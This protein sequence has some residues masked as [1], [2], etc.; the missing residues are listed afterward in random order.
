MRFD[1]GCEF[2]D[3]PDGGVYLD[4]DNLPDCPRVWEYL[5]EGRTKGIFQLEKYA[6]R[7]VCKNVMPQNK[8]QISAAITIIRPGCSKV[9]DENNITT[10]QHYEARKNGMEDVTYFH[11]EAEEILHDAYGLMIYQEHSIRLAQKFAGFDLKQADILRKA[12][13]KKDSKL[14]ASLEGEFIEGINK[15]GLLTEEEGRILFAAIRKSERYSFCKC[16]SGKETIRRL[17]KN[18]KHGVK[19]SIEEMFNIRND[20][21]YAK[22]TGHS[23]LRRKW[24]RLGNYGF[25]LSIVEGR[26]K[27]NLIKDI[28]YQGIRDVFQIELDNKATIV[29]TNN[30]KF[31][32]Q[33]GDKVLS[34]L[35]IGDSLL[36]CGKYENT[37][38]NY[39]FSN[40]TREQIKKQSKNKHFKGMC[41]FHKVGNNYFYTNGSFTE[42]KKNKSILPQ[43]CQHC[44]KTKCRLE[45]H[46]ING[47]RHDSKIENLIN[48][49]ASCHKKEEYKAGRTKI[50]EKGYPILESKIINIKY[51]GR[52]S[53]YDVEMEAPNHTFVTEQDIITCN[54]HARAYGET[55]YQTAYCKVHFPLDFFVE[56]LYW[57]KNNADPLQEVKELV[58]DA[59]YHGYEVLPPYL[60]DMQ[61]EFY[62]KRGKIYFGL[63]NIKGVG[64]KTFNKTKIEYD[65]WFNFMKTPAKMAQALVKAGACD[66]FGFSREKMLYEI[67]VW[68]SLTKTI[69]IKLTGNNLLEALRNCKPKK[70]KKEILAGEVNGEFV[71]SQMAKIQSA[72]QLLEDPPYS[73]EDS[74][75]RI[76]KYEEETLGL[77]LTV[78]KANDEQADAQCLDYAKGSISGGKFAVEITALKTW[79][80]KTGKNK[81]KMMGKITIQDMSGS[82]ENVTIFSNEYDK[83]GHLLMEGNSVLIQGEKSYSGDDLVVRAIW[84]I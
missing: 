71:P 5:A 2:K 73:L 80:I 84:Q 9:K 29:V 78:S 6:G 72:I 50:G 66:F 31:P 49:C 81:N 22:K 60:P 67:D 53:V 61:A 42:F 19:L 62:T 52:E 79:K 33:N 46:H 57:A 3:H 20:I 43:N 68:N 16:I 47:N 21:E 54:S 63:T 41:G 69:Q 34:E 36:I 26:V 8:S 35:K 56:Y 32:T 64:E 13:G 48:L 59:K 65:T 44:G 30:H 83:F 25:G 11:L 4:L 18:N 58:M 27:P 10:T 45:T 12:I 7:Q 70:T 82:L 40:M 38:K 74:P 17:N 15:V 39:A 14:L 28:R 76:A 55:A 37:T 1:C 23:V 51:I 75:S 24:K 77:C